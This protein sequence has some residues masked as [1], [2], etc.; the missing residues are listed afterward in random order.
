MGLCVLSPKLI[1]ELDEIGYWIFKLQEG[2]WEICLGLL[3][4]NDNIN[5][6]IFNLASVLNVLMNHVSYHLLRMGG[7]KNL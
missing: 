7:W 3:Q 2:F 5:S 4:W 1:E 6:L